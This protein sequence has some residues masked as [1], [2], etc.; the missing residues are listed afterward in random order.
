[1]SGKSEYRWLRVL[2]E[3]LVIIFGVLVALGVDQWREA[4]RDRQLEQEYLVRLEADLNDTRES[5]TSTIE[6][7]ATLIDHGTA[8]SRVLNG[9]ELFPKDTLGFLASALQVSR[10]GYNPAVSRGAYDDLISTGN[11]RVM[12]N[13]A[14]RYRLSA[15]YGSV[16]NDISPIDYASDKMPYRFSIRGLL[17]LETQLLIRAQCDGA[18]PL[19][20]PASE[21]V[22]GFRELVEN[23]LSAPQLRPELTVHL[24]GMAIRS[25]TDG[26]TGGFTPV[27]QQID[28][29]LVLVRASAN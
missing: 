4:A 19:T 26:V 11:L 6:D 8:V 2:A 16:Y 12:Q 22:G 23:V 21:G 5:V 18:L 28:Q 1:M 7:F 13:E 9:T 25:L 10:G 24:Q 27:L 3:F 17:T 20:C 29:L 14:L 15:F